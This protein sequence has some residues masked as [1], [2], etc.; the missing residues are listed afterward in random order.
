M[1]LENNT[2]EHFK[3]SGP[4][5]LKAGFVTIVVLPIVF[6]RASGLKVLIGL[7]KT[8]IGRMLVFPLIIQ[9]ILF[10]HEYSQVFTIWICVFRKAPPNLCYWVFNFESWWKLQ[11]HSNF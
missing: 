5:D 11:V 1:E 10:P 9:S 7:Y 6:A 4:S 3:G 8:M 2:I